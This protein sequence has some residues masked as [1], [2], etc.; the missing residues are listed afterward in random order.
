MSLPKSVD[1]SKTNCKFDSSETHSQTHFQ[2]LTGSG[3]SAIA[4]I[5][6]R[7]VQAAEIILRCFT[8]VNPRAFSKGQIRYGSWTG[9]KPPKHGSQSGF[10][11]LSTHRESIEGGNYQSI[12]RVGRALSGE[13]VVVTPCGHQ[14]YEIHCHGGPAAIGR[15]EDDLRLCGALPATPLR[16][17]QGIIESLLIR[18]AEDALI[19]CTT[20]RIAAIAMNQVRGALQ[21]WANQWRSSLSESTRHQFDLEA[22]TLLTEAEFGLRLTEP[23]RIV[24]VGPPNV[25]KSS[26]LNAIVGFDRSITLDAAGT[27]RDV[28]HAETV[29]EGLPVRVS[30]TAGIRAS[31]EPIEREGIVRA[32]MAANQADLLLLVSEP[33]PGGGFSSLPKLDRLQQEST[34]KLRILNKRDHTDSALNYEEALDHA[35]DAR[36]NA[37]SGEGIEELMINIADTLGRRLPRGEGPVLLNPRQAD[38]VKQLT[39]IASI[40]RRLEILDAL[41]GHHRG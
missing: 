32:R 30:D 13:S 16:P 22:Q 11:D 1:P 7:G 26:L 34:T 12:P 3:R 2:C 28:L 4:V 19:R 14:H 37:L 39:I 35:F 36:T 31:N 27:T 24:F 9:A 10:S 20:P 5:E 21:D 17:D 23:F 40:D 15:I 6:L 41:M 29:I 25:G 33:L 18:E 38:L 8:P